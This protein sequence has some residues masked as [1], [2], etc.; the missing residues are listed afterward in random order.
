MARAP[1]NGSTPASPSAVETPPDLVGHEGRVTTVE[2]IL[3]QLQQAA[4][5]LDVEQAANLL[6][7][8]DPAPGTGLRPDG[9]PVKTVAQQRAAINRGL[10][11]VAERYAELMPDVHK[12]LERTRPTEKT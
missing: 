5:T 12:R 7:D 9:T 8:D 11:E 4:F 3:A 1:R 10:T 2:G 6:G